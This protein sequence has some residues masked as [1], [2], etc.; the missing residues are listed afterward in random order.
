M[1]IWGQQ[2]LDASSGAIRQTRFVNNT[3]LNSEETKLGAWDAVPEGQPAFPQW[4]CKIV[5]LETDNEFD[6]ME[7]IVRKELQKTDGSKIDGYEVEL[8]HSG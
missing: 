2:L 6:G 5:R 1:P 8:Q 4:R 3:A 7:G